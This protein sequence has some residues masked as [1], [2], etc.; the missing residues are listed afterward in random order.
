MP[1]EV[2]HQMAR[3]LA[4]AVRG[5]WRLAFNVGG[6]QALLDVLA[7]GTDPIQQDV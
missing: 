2:K 4:N 3:T 6:F 7:V 1:P 5:D